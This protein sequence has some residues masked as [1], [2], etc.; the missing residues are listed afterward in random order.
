MTYETSFIPYEV[1]RPNIAHADLIEFAGNALL[2]SRAI[3]LITGKPVNHT[4]I[5][6]Q[7]QFF[8]DI[9]IRNYIYEAD[10]KG[11]HPSWLSHRVKNYKGK[12]YWYPLNPILVPHHLQ[13]VKKVTDLEGIEYD[14]LACAGNAFGRKPLDP[15]KLY[16]SEAVQ[17]GVLQFLDSLD[18]NNPNTGTEYVRTLLGKMKK[19]IYNNGYGLRPGELHLTGIWGDPIR[20]A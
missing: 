12:I 8:G 16:C 20:I 9:E 7:S 17:Y 11:F 2:P 10:E 6:V 3:R 5:M 18:L 4:S 13:I 15:K 14:W 1:A 19:T